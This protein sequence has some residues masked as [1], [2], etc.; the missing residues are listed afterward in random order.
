MFLNLCNLCCFQTSVRIL[1]SHLSY[2]YRCIISIITH[3]CYIR[4]SRYKHLEIKNTYTCRIETLVYMVFINMFIHP[5]FIVCCNLSK[6]VPLQNTQHFGSNKYTVV[7]N[8]RL[9]YW[10]N[11][12]FNED[13]PPD[14]IVIVC[15]D[16]IRV[17]SNYFS[18]CTYRPK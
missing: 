9:R 5:E 12:I 15:F 11:K 13:M 2:N 6:Y 10:E 18:L 14:N 16:W 4:I 7:F 1:H 3:K 17:N 8:S